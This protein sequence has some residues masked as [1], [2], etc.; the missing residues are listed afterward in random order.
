M[1]PI[2]LFLVSLLLLFTF[3]EGQAQNCKGESNNIS[4]DVSPGSW[5]DGFSIGA[6]Y[7]HQN[8]TIYVG[9][10]LYYFPG[11]NEL[12]FL[13]VGGRFGFN[14]EWEFS[15][16]TKARIYLGG[17]GGVIYRETGGWNY[18]YLGAEIGVQ[19]TLDSGLFG[20]VAGVRDA[21]TD[22][23][24]WS[25]DDSFNVDSVFVSIGYRF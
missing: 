22:C 3:T 23:K 19:Y 2:K 13:S 17:R 24:L 4:V 6:T 7:E 25:D 18:A 8:R 12:D 1:K 21:R 9:P 15:N 20:R 10:Q 16:F 11:L 5:D 14:K